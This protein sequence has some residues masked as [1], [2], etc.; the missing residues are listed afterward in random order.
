MK[1]MVKF[2][3]NG[4]AIGMAAGLLSWMA[5]EWYPAFMARLWDEADQ[6]AWWGE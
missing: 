4:A 1:G 6:A 2:V 3:M 5:K